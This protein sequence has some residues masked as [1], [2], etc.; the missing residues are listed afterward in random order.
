MLGHR[1]IGATLLCVLP[2]LAHAQT[3]TLNCSLKPSEVVEISSTISGVVAEVL[4]QRGQR[5][6]K[7]DP[8]LRLDSDLAQADLNVA[9]RRAGLTSGLDAARKEISTREVQIGRLRKAYSKKAIALSEMED[10][11]L[12]LSLAYTAEIQ[13]KQELEVFQ[14]E[15]ARAKLE[16]DKSIV[17]A[18]KNGI[19]GEDLAKQGESI[20]GKIVTTLTV[21]EPLRIEAF[22][23]IDMIARIDTAQFVIAGEKVDPNMVTLDYISPT[24]NL[25]SRTISTFFFLTG[26]DVTPGQGCNLKVP[27]S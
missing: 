1:I 2:N 4:V 23:P 24:A 14:A 17:Y 9:Q 22:V 27:G 12:A 18:P 20:S 15:A 8:I 5:V 19:I 26:S 25:S 13:Q 21:I 7:G 10:A 6:A 11:E 3:P 16:V